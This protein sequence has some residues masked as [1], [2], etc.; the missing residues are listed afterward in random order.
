MYKFVLFLIFMAV[1]T[2]SGQ[3]REVQDFNKLKV[4]EAPEWLEE[5]I[6][7]QMQLRAF[8]PE[9]TLNA[10]TKK[11][12]HVADLGATIVYL[13]PIFVADDNADTL[14]WSPRQ[15]ASKMN[16][17][18]NPY[19]M[20]DYFHVD[21][22]YGTNE[23]LKEFVEEAHRLGLRVMLDMVF[24]HCG[25]RAVFLEEHPDF[26]KYNEDGSVQKAEWNWPVLNF[27]NVQLR[28][29][30]ISNMEYWVRDFNVDGLRMDVSF[31][32]PLDFWET[33]RERLEKIRPDIGML[34]ESAENRRTE[35]Q[36]KAF[37][38]NYSFRYFDY[39]RKVID[40]EYPA[41]SLND[42]WVKFTNRW[43]LGA[44]FIR[45]FDNHDIS[46]DDWHNRR[47]AD[48]G[49]DACNAIFVH[50]FTLNGIPF[51][52]NGQEIADTARH[53]IFGNAPIHWDMTETLVGQSRF[54]FLQN[55]CTIYSN[56]SALQY[57]KTDWLENDQPNEV[58][59]YVRKNGNDQ[60]LTIVNLSNYPVSVK[61]KDSDLFK[62]K[63]FETLLEN[64][65]SGNFQDGFEIQA[66]GFYV[67]KIDCKK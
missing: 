17:P 11:L 40:G 21:A 12:S 22:E 57:G 28:E 55:M 37:D 59:S 36:L 15:K 64:R 32:I 43:P 16:N 52:Y 39:L 33:T 14:T 47:E 8:T 20:K 3:N 9:G 41:S 62:T 54:Q 50:L 6:I 29:Y 19:R 35:D 48:W 7:Y 49:F 46:N 53:S 60:I 1:L 58:L 44:R 66:Y 5:G 63:I 56:E 51:I 45:Y 61:L 67:V 23:D 13:C 30:L 18:R 34:S 4:R 31:A 42:I 27:K 10:A 2:A 25:S 65:I 38:A 26:I 24:L